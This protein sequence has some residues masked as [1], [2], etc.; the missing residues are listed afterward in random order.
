MPTETKA[1]R[2]YF[3]SKFQKIQSMRSHLASCTWAEHMT[4]PSMWVEGYSPHGGQ[5]VENK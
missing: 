3:G 4:V 1:E 2:V 5:K